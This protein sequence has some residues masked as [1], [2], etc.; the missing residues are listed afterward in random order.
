MQ[1][2]NNYHTQLQYSGF[3]TSVITDHAVVL[4]LRW[5]Y[6]GNRNFILAPTVSS[7]LWKW[8]SCLLWCIQTCLPDSHEFMNIP[9]LLLKLALEKGC[10]ISTTFLYLCDCN[11]H[12][13]KK[14]WD[15]AGDIIWVFQL[16][17]YKGFYLRQF[18]QSSCVSSYKGS[19]NTITLSYYLSIAVKCATQMEIDSAWCQCVHFQSYTIKM[20]SL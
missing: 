3:Y 7:K 10:G 13:G 2:H 9:L 8:K 12:R 17:T 6:I 5:L 4:F 16:G 15:R 1:A 19:N 11:Y 14:R 20:V 18:L